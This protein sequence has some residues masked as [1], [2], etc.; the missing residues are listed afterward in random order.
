MELHTYHESSGAFAL[1]FS[2]DFKFLNANFW[3]SI[4]DG[5]KF[6]IS[7]NNSDKYVY[8]YFK[9][10]FPLYTQETQEG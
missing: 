3:C 7:C 5:L 8:E 6:V 1:L 9:Y 2:A 4:T 10:S